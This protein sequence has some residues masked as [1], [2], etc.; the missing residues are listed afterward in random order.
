LRALQPSLGK[1]LL[2]STLP[3]YGADIYGGNFSGL[4]TLLH[5]LVSVASRSRTKLLRDHETSLLVRKVKNQAL[6]ALLTAIAPSWSW[7]GV[8]GAF[9]YIHMHPMDD[10]AEHE[11]LL[12]ILEATCTPSDAR[13]ISAVYAGEIRVKGSL[14]IAGVLI[15]GPSLH[16]IRLTFNLRLDDESYADSEEVRRAIKEIMQSEKEKRQNKFHVGLPPSQAGTDDKQADS[17]R[18]ENPGSESARAKPQSPE[19]GALLPFTQYL[20]AL[21]RSTYACSSRV[22]ELAKNPRMP[23][24]SSMEEGNDF[25]GVRY[26]GHPL[27]HPQTGAQVGYWAPDYEGS[28][29]QYSIVCLAVS[30]YR[31]YVLCLGLQRTGRQKNRYK[32]IGLAFWNAN[33][34]DDCNGLGVKECIIV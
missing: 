29:V 19:Q 17:P 24:L 20:R 11:V 2:T 7:A 28:D 21:D 27:T 9:E 6:F 30:K 33:A 13:S 1:L 16:H 3:D 12:N 8:Q 32:R 14:K 18:A 26:P 5:L 4:C 23:F 10:H 31:G 15:G 25:T 34:W 22:S